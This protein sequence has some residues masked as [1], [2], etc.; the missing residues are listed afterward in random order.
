VFLSECS[1]ISLVSVLRR[2][3]NWEDSRDAELLRDRV[4]QRAEVAVAVPRGDERVALLLGP[5]ARLHE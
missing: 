3:G 4:I 2:L 1:Q 5:A